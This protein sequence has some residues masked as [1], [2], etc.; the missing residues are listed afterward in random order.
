MDELLKTL[1]DVITPYLGQ[2]ASAAATALI[3]LIKRWYDKR[4]I[5]K[6]VTFR[7]ASQ[8]IPH[9]E[10]MHINALIDNV[11]YSEMSDKIRNN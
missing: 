5:H 2:L 3:A 8:G 1:I 7:L 6:V 10:I 4:Q 11:K 9:E